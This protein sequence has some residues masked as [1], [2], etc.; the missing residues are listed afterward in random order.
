MVGNVKNL[1][2]FDIILE[3]LENGNFE[4]FYVKHSKKN[5]KVQN[6]NLIYFKLF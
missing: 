6:K 1:F 4:V 5:L 3:V 2:C